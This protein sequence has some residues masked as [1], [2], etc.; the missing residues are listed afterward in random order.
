MAEKKENYWKTLARK[1]KEEIEKIKSKTSKKNDI[2]PIM[3][4]ILSIFLVAAVFGAGYLAMQYCSV[5]SRYES[6]KTSF[7]SQEAQKD[8]LLQERDSLSSQV[9]T[10]NGRVSDL[11]REK[12]QLTSDLST[13]QD[14][15]DETEEE[16]KEKEDALKEKNTEIA[17]LNTDIITLNSSIEDYQAWIE[18]YKSTINE[19][20][21][22]LGETS[23]EVSD[24][25][26]TMAQCIGCGICCVDIEAAG[27]PSYDA[28]TNSTTQHYD[29]Y[30]FF[31]TDCGTCGSS[32]CTV[33]CCDPCH[34]CCNI[35][36]PYV[37]VRMRVVCDLDIAAAEDN[38][39]FTTTILSW[40][41]YH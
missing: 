8:S 21:E 41:W 28:G 18:R 12:S 25:E 29:L 9:D 23:E 10:L 31:D 37:R 32:Y 20:N 24:L 6:L 40:Y 38:N 17:D 15:L 27:D 19:L 34:P 13:L 1:Q 2:W 7:E 30:L 35:C 33:S 11:Q 26:E 39:T 3:A 36:T 5:D 22:R 14:E 4:I 16:K